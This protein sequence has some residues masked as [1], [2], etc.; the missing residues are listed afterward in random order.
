MAEHYSSLIEPP[1]SLKLNAAANLFAYDSALMLH[2]LSFILMYL[3]DSE[4]L[5]RH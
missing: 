5:N 2:P 1:N 4:L 3:Q